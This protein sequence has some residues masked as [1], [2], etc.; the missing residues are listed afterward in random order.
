MKNQTIKILSPSLVVSGVIHFD[1]V[2]SVL[3]EVDF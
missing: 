2:L 1:N 3:G